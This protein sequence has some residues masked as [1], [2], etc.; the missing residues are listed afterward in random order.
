MSQTTKIDNKNNKLS[1][2]INIIMALKNNIVLRSELGANRVILAVFK[3][4]NMIH[5]SMDQ[6]VQFPN[7]SQIK[8]ARCLLNITQE[9]CALNIGISLS[10]LKKYEQLSDNELVL[11]HV[12][13]QLVTKILN[14]FESANVKFEKTEDGISVSLKLSK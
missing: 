7:G 3:N 2:I 6:R 14:Y 1:S 10:T 11:E 4:I 8:A 12:R 5:K 9:H 13:Y